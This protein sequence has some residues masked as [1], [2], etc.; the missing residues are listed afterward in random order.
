M[1]SLVQSTLT[2][3]AAPLDQLIDGLTAVLGVKLGEADV[4]INGLRCKG[5]ALVA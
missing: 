4:K 3:V 5:A 1:V 2:A